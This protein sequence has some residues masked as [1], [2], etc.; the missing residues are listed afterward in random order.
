MIASTVWADFVRYVALA[1]HTALTAELLSKERGA[2]FCFS[3]L[4]VLFKLYLSQSYGYIYTWKCGGPALLATEG[5]SR[6]CPQLSLSWCVLALLHSYLPSWNPILLMFGN[7]SHD[8][9]CRHY[10]WV[11][12]CQ[13]SHYVRVGR[14]FSLISSEYFLI[15]VNLHDILEGLAHCD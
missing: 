10:S 11:E 6:W 4:L 9:K 15:G 1:K 7:W 14:T 8:L 13:A 3:V 2:S 12:K 5:L